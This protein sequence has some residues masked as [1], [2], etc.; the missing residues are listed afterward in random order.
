M[1][2]GTGAPAVLALAPAV[3]M[4]AD[5]GAPAVLALAP[6]AVMLAHAGAPAVLALAPDAVMLADADATIT[7]HLLLTV[8]IQQ[9]ACAMRSTCLCGRRRW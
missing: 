3:V 7:P 8:M 1:L 6:D 9:P 4:L 5:A 2:A